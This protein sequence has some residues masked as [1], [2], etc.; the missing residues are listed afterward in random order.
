MAKIAGDSMF[1]GKFVWKN[2][3]K[4]IRTKKQRK[5]AKRGKDKWK[6]RE[7]III[8]D[9]NKNKL[10]NGNTGKQNKYRWR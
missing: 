5:A 2:R 6:R 8:F 9:A 4:S 1:R 7:R 10:R 3:I